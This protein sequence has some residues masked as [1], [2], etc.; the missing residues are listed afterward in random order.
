MSETMEQYE[1][2]INASFRKFEEGD[3]VTG[4]ITSVADD[5]ITLDLNS[6]AQGVVKALEVS[7]D[8]AFSIR[9]N[10]EVGQE[11]SA[12]VLSG[13]DGEGSVSLSIRQATEILAW[14]KLKE[15][16]ENETNLSLTV[17]GVVKG[18]VITYVEGIRGFIP[19]SML[20]LSYV[21]D[22]T[23][24]LKK[25][26]TA[27]VVEIDP[28]KKRLILSCRVILKEQ[29]AEERER[30][31]NSIAVGTVLEG[32]VESLQTYG[33]FI[34]LGDGISG[35]VHISQ[36]S[37]KRIKKP[38]EVLSV[39][40]KVKVKVIKIADG[41]IGLSMK[42]LEE[43]TEKPE[44]IEVFDYKETG[45]ASTSLGSLLSGFDFEE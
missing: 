2:E 24:W 32:T 6:Y 21:E 29:Q 40:D 26:I 20:S 15:Y 18:G 4:T 35:L 37:Q 5:E 30:K 9:D 42:V 12:V 1:Q 7:A 36:I 23:T 38:A 44:T 34:D 22:L 43:V 33:A 8:P 16:M 13:D 17:G 31:I 45:E 25:E 41:K 11:V 27:R 3:M 10:M 39:G 19:A 14:D 28:D